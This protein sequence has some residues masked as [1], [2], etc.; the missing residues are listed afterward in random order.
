MNEHQ[1]LDKNIEADKYEPK[2]FDEHTDFT[3]L[4]NEVEIILLQRLNKYEEYYGQ[5][6]KDVDGAYLTK[7]WVQHEAYGA[8]HTEG[9][10]EE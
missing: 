8:N 3:F 5:V 7:A 2:A 4:W 6:Q 9:N 10:R 1:V